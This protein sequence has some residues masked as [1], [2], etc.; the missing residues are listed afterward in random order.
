M[1]PPVNG[2]YAP[3]HNFDGFDWGGGG[4]PGRLDRLNQGP[5]S[6]FQDDGWQTFMSTTPSERP[7]RSFGM[8]FVGYAWEEN[9][10]PPVEG[11]S[12][13]ESVTALA[14]LPFVDKLYIRCDWR[15]VQSQAGKL[16]LDPVFPL[17]L[18]LCKEYNLGLG[19]RIQMSSPNIHPKLAMPD[20]LAEK[21]P[22]V[23]IGTLKYPG[24][25]DGAFKEP[26]YHDAT[27]QKAFRELNEL[28][29]AE[30]D[31]DERVEWIDLMQ[32]GMWGEGHSGNME[33]SLPDFATAL[34]TFLGMTRFQIETWKK[35][36]LAVNTQPDITRVGN[37]AV[38]DMCLRAGE[39]MRTDSILSIEESQQIEMISNRPPG[40][41]IVVE[42]GAN[43]RYVMDDLLRTAE[44]ELTDR[45]AA[46]LLSLDVGANYWCLWQMADNL[47]AFDERFPGCFSTVRSKVGYRVRPSWVHM[48][49]RYGRIELVA[50]IKND[51]VASVPGHLKVWV[52]S[53]D[54]TLKI[55]GSLDRGHPLPG[56]LRHASFLLP[57]GHDGEGLL[58]RAE[59][60]TKGVTRPVEWACREPL[61]DE[62]RL[63]L[64]HNN[65]A[66]REWRKDV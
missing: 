36:P 9:G 26:A 42:D 34:D 51:G 15:N 12:V 45:E 37:D 52:E 20:F 25:A 57:E 8:G 66:R 64:R 11:A 2:P 23:E 5:F 32:Y 49:K 60:E 29:A 58:M 10:P 7:L 38:I 17:A 35:T 63:I 28:M 39:W 1:D 50:I 48:R 47:A 24:A 30:F 61:D 19:I 21:V 62:G 54:G 14:K 13:E 59:I 18:A 65:W 4:L 46:A 40:C 33:N 56:R 22:V 55:G 41:A 44:G 53:P 3:F 31:D 6:V 27:F 16:D 43:R